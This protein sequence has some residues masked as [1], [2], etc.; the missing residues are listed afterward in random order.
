MNAKHLKR[1]VFALLAASSPL[2]SGE[3]VLIA[4][5]NASWFTPHWRKFNEINDFL[6]ISGWVDIHS[7]RSFEIDPEA[8]Y[9]LSGMFRT[10]QNQ[11]TNTRFEFGFDPIDENG[12]EIPP[13]T[14]QNHG[15]SFSA[16]ATPAKI[17]DTSIQIKTNANWDSFGFVAFH[18]KQ[19][20]SDLPNKDCLPYSKLEKRGDVMILTLKTP[21]KKDY[22]VNTPVRNHFRNRLWTVNRHTSVG[23][24]WTRFSGRI[25]GFSKNAEG[26]RQWWPGSCRAR[27]FLLVGEK[28]T[29]EF[30]D[31]SV[32]KV[33]K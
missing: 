24:E 2:L 17:G 27:I 30:K 21:L 20:F 14:V 32:K 5:T 3:E 1:L 28:Q 22:P 19:D 26:Y 7:K 25:R 31:V 13:Y 11:T 15:N 10:P 6:S 16:L 12:D 29:I 18:A 4:C 9:E 8:E 23:K 33:S